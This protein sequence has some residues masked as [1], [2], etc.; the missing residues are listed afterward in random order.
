MRFLVFVLVVGFCFG[1]QIKVAAAANL[2]QALVAI[3]TA[4]LRQHPKD[5]IFLSFGSSG[6]L[7]NQITQGAPYD[8]FISADKQRPSKLVADGITSYPVRVYARGIL[9]LWSATRPVK[10]LEVLQGSYNHLAIANPTLAP[11]GRASIEVLQKLHLVDVLQLKI[12]EA[13]SVAQANAYV[14]S[15][16]AQL[17]FSALSLMQMDKKA[18]YLI[19]P[20]EYYSPIEQ[21]MVLTKWGGTKKLAKDFADFILSSRGQAILKSHGYSVAPF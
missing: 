14:A 20:Q 1:E 3:K 18:H 17:G 16:A 12:A 8:L 6:H 15:K 21:A 11:Y 10:S 19:V 9:V 4:F 5:E 2:S 7:F 13:S